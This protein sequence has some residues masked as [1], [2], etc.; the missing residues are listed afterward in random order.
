MWF[1]TFMEKFCQGKKSQNKNW[2]LDF[3][4]LD[5]SSEI[6]LGQN[7][8]LKKKNEVIYQ[9]WYKKNMFVLL[10]INLYHLILHHSWWQ[11]KWKL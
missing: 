1:L 2:S 5:M 7:F 3:T 11:S 8:S 10:S 9:E 4:D 6:S